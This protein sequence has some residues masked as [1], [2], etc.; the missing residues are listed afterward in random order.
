MKVY[1][2]R[3]HKAVLG[4]ALFF[5]VVLVITAYLA[6]RPHYL[7]RTDLV[8]RVVILRNKEEAFIFIQAEVDGVSGSTLKLIIK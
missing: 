7:L 2:T 4:I 5:I 3:A 6:L 1:L 8:D